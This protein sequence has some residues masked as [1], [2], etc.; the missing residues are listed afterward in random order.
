MAEGLV[1]GI[2]VGFSGALAAV[3]KTD[4]VSLFPMPVMMGMGSNRVDVRAI[5]EWLCPI[6]RDH[7]IALVVIEHAKVMNKARGGKEI[8][9]GVTGM[10]NFGMGFGKL[11]GMFEVLGL[12]M[13]EVKP[14]DWKKVVLR[15]FKD[16]NK[17]A[18]ISLCQQRFPQTR[19]TLPKGKKPQDGWA[20]AI[21]LALYGQTRIG[22]LL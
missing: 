8:K 16:K 7:G 17:D 21:C 2:D 3:S 1:I 10:F 5:K 19:L 20:D 6:W 9:Q 12:K 18:A 11:L 15:G 4:V 13:E 14:E 22:N